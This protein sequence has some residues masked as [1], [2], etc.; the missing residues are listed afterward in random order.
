MAGRRC[1]PSARVYDAY[2]SAER[3][4]SDRERQGRQAYYE[5]EA[6]EAEF[7]V[8]RLLRTFEE[9]PAAA[10][11]AVA[12]RV[13]APQLNDRSPPLPQHGNG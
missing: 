13:P 4:T 10:Q 6:K 1:A 3:A 2:A 9:G 8:R 12:G 5:N 11:L 7:E